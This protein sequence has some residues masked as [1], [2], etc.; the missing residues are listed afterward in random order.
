MPDFP[1][2]P[3]GFKGYVFHFPFLED[4][5]SHYLKKCQ[6]HPKI[7]FEVISFANLGCRIQYISLFVIL[8]IFSFLV[9]ADN[10]YYKYI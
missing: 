5:K 1:K 10:F 2:I 8:A 3:L 9:S 7:S 4:L 6:K